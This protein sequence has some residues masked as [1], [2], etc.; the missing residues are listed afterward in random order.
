[1]Q[2]TSR[3]QFTKLLGA[4][5]ALAASS[6]LFGSFAYAQGKGR[7]VVV[8]GGA[9]G[10]TVAHLVKRSA[11]DLEVTLVEAN[12]QYTSCFFSNLFLGGFRS[13]ESITHGYD[14]LTKLGVKVIHDLATDVDA[15]KK[16]VSLQSGDILPYDKLVLSPGIDFKYDSIEGYSAET[17]ATMPHAWKGGEQTK[18]LKSQLDAMEPGGTVVMAAPPNPFRCPPGPYERACMIAHHLKTK[19]PGSRLVIFDPKPKFSKMALFQE[20]WQSHYSDIVEWVPPDM[21][22]GGVKRVDPKT[23]TVYTG[24]G[25]ATKAAVANIIPAQKAGAIAEKAGCVKDDWC[26]INSADFSSALVENVYVL[27]DASVAAAMPKSAFSANN[28]AKSVANAVLAALAAKKKFPARYRNTCWSL[29]SPEN[30]VKVGASYKP[31]E[32][33]VEATETFISKT[34]EDL[35]LRTATFKESLGWYDAITTEMFAKG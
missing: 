11:P 22:D 21:T 17:A 34:G 3:R 32:K 13:F 1:M 20:G 2:K 33:K 25:K 5:G 28:Q 29:I 7:V 19:K 30:G 9:G 15:N 14:G 10:A 31:G 35:A 18:T 12:P 8:G 16:T 4:S 26:P 6:S 27:G 24:D 23:M